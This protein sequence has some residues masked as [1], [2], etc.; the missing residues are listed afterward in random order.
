MPSVPPSTDP[1]R[2]PAPATDAALRAARRL[3][4]RFLL[5]DHRLADVLVVGEAEPGLVA[6]LT[7][8][9]LAASVSLAP[10]PA[11][12]AAHSADVVVAGRPHD[13]ALPAAAAAVR[14][15]GWVVA[16][17]PGPV[18]RAGRRWRRDGFGVARRAIRRLRRRD[19]DTLDAYLV[20]PAHDAA[21]AL[22]PL[23]RP[24]AIA[25]LLERRAPARI[26]SAVGR[27][28]PL[29]VTS[30]LATLVAPAV[31]I[32][33][34]R[35]LAAGD[36]GRARRFGATGDTTIP[37]RIREVTG[38]HGT[39]SVGPDDPVLLLTPRY[40]AS[41]HVV[42]LVLDAS[43]RLP[44]LVAKAARLPSSHALEREA[45]ALAA[46]AD[47]LGAAGLAPR[48]V[49]FDPVGDPPMLVETGLPGRP[50]APDA[51][52]AD[53][54]VAAAAVADFAAALP[55]GNDRDG[56][57][58][59]RLVEPAL[60][61]LG[62]AL[63]D[64]PRDRTHLERTAAIVAPLR[65]A[66]LPHVLEHGD[67]AHPNLLLGPGN[68]L[69][70]VDWERSEPRGLPLHDLVVGLAYVAGAA[71]GARLPDEAAAAFARA[72]AGP[73]GWAGPILDTELER[74]GIDPALRLPLIVV[75]WLRTA[76][77][78][79][80]HLG[81]PEGAGEGDWKAWLRMDRS[82]AL[83]RATLGLAR[84]AR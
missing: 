1:I 59:K 14:P 60:A 66:R 51:V 78:L 6:A 49:G 55:V 41:S 16:E 13:R 54:A 81:G 65:S 76:A 63:A 23:D 70:A 83:W 45:A 24:A 44:R 18:W 4:W 62:A 31:T 84:E 72:V 69:A 38:D 43:T 9:A 77:W 3:D 46:L 12:V 47:T 27:L 28:T 80:A 74:L 39:P 30:G 15:G 21:T 53:R 17:V 10:D 35:R 71:E 67:L 64:D 2:A 36:A 7:T 37:R 79:A 57:A 22:A 40:R 34:R 42:A 11:R 75:P 56:S 48:L 82:V 58:F 33:A 52:R 61:G 29:A 26:R 32:V 19:I 50:L 73:D 68:R 25:A 20:W 8:A 5:D